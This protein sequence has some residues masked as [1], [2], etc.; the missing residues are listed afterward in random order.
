MRANSVAYAPLL[1][2]HFRLFVPKTAPHYFEFQP[3]SA[4]KAIFFKKT[5][6]LS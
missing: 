5:Y 1:E 2:R 4:H 6:I 3:Y